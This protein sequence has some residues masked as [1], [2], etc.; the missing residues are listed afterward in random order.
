M[1]K[2]VRSA[3]V[4]LSM[5][6]PPW[7]AQVESWTE[8]RLCL[9]GVRFIAVVSFGKL[10]ASLSGLDEALGGDDAGAKTDDVCCEVF[11]GGEDGFGGHWLES[12]EDE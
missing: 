10:C 7:T 12:V 11:T 8:D 5:L 1:T 6:F 4:P 3:P 2:G 9:S